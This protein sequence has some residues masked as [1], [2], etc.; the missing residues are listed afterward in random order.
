MAGG[1][2]GESHAFNG[3]N[4]GKQGLV[5]DLRTA[6][7]REVFRR[8]VRSADVVVEN[9]RPGVMAKFGLD[10]ATLSAETARV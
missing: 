7:A 10:Y 8:L 4:R 2:A 5:L 1:V 6:E 3:V 9:F